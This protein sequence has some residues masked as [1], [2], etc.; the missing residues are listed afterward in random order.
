MKSFRH[1]Y[2]SLARWTLT[3]ALLL[4]SVMASA[5]GAAAAPDV[6]TIVEPGWVLSQSTTTTLP[7]SAT[8]NPMDGLLYFGRRP[9]SNTSAEL[10]RINADGSI[11][12][13]VVANTPAGIVVDPA[14]G[15]IFVSQDYGGTVYRV[16]FGATTQTTWLSGLGGGDDDPIGM[17]IAPAGYSGPILAA[18]EALLVD[19]GYSGGADAIWKWSP[20]IAEGETLIYSDASNGGTLSDPVDVAI[21]PSAIYLV[22]TKATAAGAIFRLDA[23]PTLT[24]ITTS[25]PIADPYGITI[26]PLTGDLWVLDASPD[27]LLRV[28]P[29]TGAVSEMITGFTGVS[30]A[31]V[32]ATPDGNHIFVSDYSGGTIYTFSR[33]PLGVMLAAFEAVAQP[34][35]IHVSWETAS[36][37]E[38]AGFNLYRS[39][40]AS[41]DHATLLAYV[42]SQAPGSA[43]G[44]VYGYD[45]AGVA[46]GQTA[47]YWLED[48]DFAGVT[49]EHGPVQATM[50]A[51]T[52]VRLA[53]FGVE[54]GGPWQRT[55]A[56]GGSLAL[57]AVS[58]L[59]LGARRTKTRRNPQNQGS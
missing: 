1:L 29:T 42:P 56:W 15:D 35:A 50:A 51:P 10:K 32:D 19:R 20:A 54:A 58:G 30:W 46:P 27:R 53:S 47:W 9:G 52:A 11:S 22:D 5:P 48:V 26:D 21:G 49:S 31:G 28:N 38:N 16:A 6:V 43:Q 4:G 7:V 17:A 36:E 23:G 2:R 14:D 37:L 40:D 33:A 39:L 44:F 59:W 57:L 45:D 13:V 12:Q 18:G 34:N 55:L 24:Q 25:E 41:R 3:I 8:Y